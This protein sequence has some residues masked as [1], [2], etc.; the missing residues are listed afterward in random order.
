M[1]TKFAVI[2]AIVLIGTAACGGDDG[3]ADG[4]AAPASGPATASATARHNAQDVTFAQMMIPHHR[5]AVEMTRIVIGKTKDPQIERLARQIAKAQSPEIETMTTWL[6][7]WGAEVPAEDDAMGTSG[8]GGHSGH[9]AHG[10]AMHG[11]MT[12]EQMRKLSGLTGERMDRAFL[13]MMIEH[14]EGAVAMARQEQA[15]GADPAAKNL[16]ASIIKTQQAEI[17]E[18]TTLLKQ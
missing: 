4:A 1:K 18:M 7:A 2:A 12:A 14:H 10:A 16:A 8:D 15:K 13:T 17:D 6:R 9:E 3:G 11:M 5:Q